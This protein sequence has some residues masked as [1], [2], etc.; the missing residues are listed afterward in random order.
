MTYGSY[1]R[2]N[3]NLFKITIP[4]TLA[5]VLVSMLAGIAI[6]TALFTFSSEITSG[7]E[8]IFQALPLVFSQ[9]TLGPILAF[10]FFALILFAGLTSQISAM[11]P[12]ISYLT[13]HFKFSRHKAVVICGGAVLALG[14]PVGLSYGVAPSFKIFGASFFDSLSFFC[15]NILIPFGAL[16]AVALVSWRNPFADFMNHIKQGAEG[17]VEG[18]RILHTLL[19]ISLKFV[20]PLVILMILLNSFF[21]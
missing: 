19:L 17:F 18:N 9:M 4:V 2:K 15:V 7:S 6:F 14:L 20:A 12:M 16:A 21:Q 3:D 11:E 8:L 10:M 13:D 1:L 5:I